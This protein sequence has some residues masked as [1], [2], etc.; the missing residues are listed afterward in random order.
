[1]VEEN[2]IVLYTN[3]CPRCKILKQKLDDKKINYKVCND[4]QVMV[5]K[6][7]KAVPALEI[8]DKIFK[9]LDAVNWVNSHEVI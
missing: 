4:I 5:L 7:L 3:D 6:G 9:F 2:E 8:D 1:M